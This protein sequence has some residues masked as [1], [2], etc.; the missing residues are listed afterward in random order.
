MPNVVT[1]KVDHHDPFK[2]ANIYIQ[3]VDLLANIDMGLSTR[4]P[5][6][7]NQTAFIIT[8]L[9]DADWATMMFGPVLCQY[10]YINCHP[11][12]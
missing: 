9:W 4:T 3:T 1:I 11:S 7:S 8:S 2:V 10:L 12:H 6:A 5:P